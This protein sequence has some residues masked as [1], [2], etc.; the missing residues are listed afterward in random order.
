MRKKVNVVFVYITFFLF[1][2][3]NINFDDKS[4]Y[5]NLSPIVGKDLRF[6]LNSRDRLKKYY[7]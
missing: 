6:V 7:N 2:K 1:S 5:G 3:S 4:I